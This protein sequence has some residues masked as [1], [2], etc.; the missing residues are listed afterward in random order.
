MDARFFL[1]VATQGQEYEVRVKGT[2]RLAQ[3]VVLLIVA[4][5]AAMAVIGLSGLLSRERLE[6]RAALARSKEL[7]QQG[8]ARQALA[9]VSGLREDAPWAAELLEIRG[10]AYSAVRETEAARRALERALD[11]DPNRAMAAKVLAAIAFSRS[12]DARGIEY[13]KRA[14]RIDPGDFRPWYAIGEALLRLGQYDDAARAFEQS[15]KLKGS[16]EPSRIGLL[17]ARLESRPPEEST[18]LLRVLLERLPDDA[19]IQLLAAR[20]ARALGDSAAAL[21]YAETAASLDPGLVEALVLRAQLHAAAGRSEDA[22]AAAQAAVD[23]QPTNLAALN[24]L[25][26]LQAGRGDAEAA[27]ET[28]A[29][30]RAILERNERM[31]RLSQEIDEHPDDPKPRWELG[32]MA[33]EAGLRAFAIENFRAALALDP[34]CPEALEGLRSLAPVRGDAPPDSLEPPSPWI[35]A[36]R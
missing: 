15:L 4:A 8:R 5:G 7:L 32:R 29:R 22:F 10:L 28:F 30:H 19:Q 1:G 9:A 11:L 36:I 14:A 27:R 35:G 12:E 20:H 3:G 6:A 25:A 23:L 24:L 17:R 31:H 21:R 18:E 26:Q 13:L 34:N 16:H 2:R 33:A